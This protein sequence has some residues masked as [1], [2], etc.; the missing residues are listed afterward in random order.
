MVRKRIWYVRPTDHNTETD[1]YSVGSIDWFAKQLR[2]IALVAQSPSSTLDLHT[3]IYVTCLCNPEGLPPIPNCDVV[4]ERPKIRDVINR[5]IESHPRSSSSSTREWSEKKKVQDGP[6]CLGHATPDTQLDL[7]LDIEVAS[8]TP[9]SLSPSESLQSLGVLVAGPPSLIRETG[10]AVEAIRRS[11][12]LN[13]GGMLDV[14][15]CG[16]VYSV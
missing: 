12:L 3:T 14:G 10:I 16:E 9:S 8:T 6:E 1:G 13:R 11:S 5:V 7:D 2:Q 4:V 15:F